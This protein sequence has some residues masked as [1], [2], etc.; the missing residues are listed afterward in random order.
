MVLSCVSDKENSNDFSNSIVEFTA[1]QKLLQ[2]YLGTTEGQGG[3]GLGTRTNDMSGL[4]HANTPQQLAYHNGQLD[5][6]IGNPPGFN[7]SKHH[8]KGGDTNRSSKDAEGEADATLVCFLFTFLF[9]VLFGFYSTVCRYNIR[10]V[11]PPLPPLY[12]LPL[13]EQQSFETRHVSRF[14]FFFL[15][16]YSFSYTNLH[17]DTIYS[18]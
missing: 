18:V 1:S 12:P 8:R 4:G 17:L 3:P 11:W 7:A 16:F 15:S 14:C 10:H 6:S 13:Q 2:L 5:M 9:F